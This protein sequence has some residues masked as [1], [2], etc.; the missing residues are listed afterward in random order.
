M[1]DEELSTEEACQQLTLPKKT[2][3]SV[4]NGKIMWWKMDSLNEGKKA[5]S[6]VFRSYVLPPGYKAF[7]PSIQKTLL[8]Y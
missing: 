2:G 3:I 5:T 1:E 6:I 4:D 8:F 7:P